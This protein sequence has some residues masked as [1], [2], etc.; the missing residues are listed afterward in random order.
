MMFKDEN[1]KALS[2]YKVY[3]NSALLVLNG[4]SLNSVNAFLALSQ[5]YTCGIVLK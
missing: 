2:L 5:R 1:Q 4:T 3:G